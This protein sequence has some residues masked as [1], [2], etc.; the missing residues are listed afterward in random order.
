MLRRFSWRTAAVA[1]FAAAGLLLGSAP[2]SAQ[3]STGYTPSEEDSLL[4][5]LQVRNVTLGGEIRGY[6]TPNGVCVDLADVIQSLDL[7]I[8]LDKKSRRATGWVFAEDQKFSIDRDSNRV[9]NVNNTR[10]LQPGELYDS[11]EGW[12]VD[13]DSLGGWLGVSFKTNL[14]A[15]SLVLESDRPLPFLE[16]RER[17]SR[18]A[19]LRADRDPDLASYPQARQPYALWRLPSVDVVASADYSDGSGNGRL[20]ARYEIYA[21]GEIARAS[22]AMR[23]AS[24]S[25]GVPQSLRVRAFRMDP[26][27][28][29]L[30]PL[31][32]TQAAVGDV[33][34]LSG[35][36]AGATGVGRGV[37]LSNREIARPTRFG[38]TI[39]RG[40]LPLGWDAELYRNGQLLAYQGSTPDGRYEFEVSLLYGRND[41]E[42]V[43]YGPQ[44]QVRRESQSIPVGGGAVEP[45]K[46]EYWAGIIQRNRDLIEFS[47]GPPG[48]RLDN[49][50]QFGAGAQYGLDRRTV[51]G[52][53]GH[54]LY[55]NAKRH[56]YAEL[57]LQRA[58]GPM[59]LNLSAAQEFGAGRA[60]RAEML[61]QF[62]KVNVQ[63]ESFFVDGRFVSGLI[64]L[65]EQS[66]HRLQV[67]TVLNAGRTPI[68]ISAG[69]RRTTQRNG[70]E[71]N[72][73][74]LR[75]SVILPRAA[76][77]GFVVH[78]DSV[79]GYDEEEGT[80]IGLLANT[81]FLGFTVRGEADY[82]ISGPRR[83][84]DEASLTIERAL[85]DRSDLRLDVQHT[86]RSG[87]T[88][89]EFGYVRHFK[90]LSLL[91]GGRVDSRGSIG[92][93]LA[94]NFSFGPNPLGGGWRMSS[95]KLA[96]RGAAAVAVFLDENGDGVRSAGE[97]AL[98]EV[99]VTAGQYGESDPTDERGFAMVEGLPPYQKVL[100]SVDESTLPD[101]FL[102]PRG[103]GIV[104]TPRPG[105]PAVVELAVAP[106]G[107]AEGLLLGPEGTPLAG[108]QLE[109]VD[110]RGSVIAHTMSEYD[111]F[112][113]FDR[114]VYGKYRLQLSDG[115]RAVLG[116]APD[117]ATEVE[118]GPDKTLHRL[119]TI[120][121]HSATTIAQAR[122]PP[123]G[124][125]P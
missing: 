1:T 25:N 120:R 61:G 9:Q 8:R 60:Y 48:S 107:E 104:V 54:S 65:N 12:C 50:W 93:N 40:T 56:D 69:F 94:I 118:L 7:P 45:G 59:L 71:V 100:L 84:F 91:A 66:S 89:F 110:D 117:L 24:D 115:S 10:P 52:A 17:Q 67:D 81:R 22:Y 90:K 41:L 101:P 113:L 53:S 58:L 51:I 3:A 111:G 46:L 114:V 14:R 16:Q 123:V 37:F 5:Q 121:L 42:V 49:G 70:R 35:N 34:I 79:G 99:G 23:L 78:R 83:G 33:D 76:F 28:Q 102:M 108:A 77:T 27:G 112:F 11:P 4:L 31:H 88:D 55:L 30:G 124:S 13:T 97:Q 62:G 19:R 47:R 39:V 63:A 125:S 57:N 36:L 98:P 106:T 18:A 119:G 82:R 87:V 43:L 21:S 64:G 44:G 105:V 96:Q 95:E 2:A 74:L 92:A 75:G 86:A 103:K 116:V 68:P 26:D 29:M 109:L 122:G 80:D 73:F 20:N 72:E 15:S 6:Q 38:T 85:S 32:A